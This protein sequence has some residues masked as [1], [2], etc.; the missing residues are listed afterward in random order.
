VRRLRR[1]AH[2]GLEHPALSTPAVAFVVVAFVLPMAVMVLYSFW[3]TRG[4]D[5]VRDFTLDNYRRLFDEPLYVRTLLR[6]F[7]VVGLSSL[8]TVAV[9]FPFAYFVAVKVRPR[10]RLAWILL[11]VLPFFTSYLIRVF[12]W[13]NIFGT[14]GAA[15]EAIRALGLSD[16]PVGF[17]QQGTSAIV[18]TFVYLLFPLAFLTSY[19]TLERMDPGLREAA[20]DLGAKPWQVLAKVTI[21][22]AGSGL[23][24]GFAF[25]FIAMAGDYVT[26]RLIGGTKGSLFSNLIVNQ[27]GLSVQWGYGA[28]LALVLLVSVLIFLILLRV[29][30]GTRAAGDF[31]RRYEYR[32]APVLAAYSSAFVMFLYLPIVLVVLFA[33]NTSSFVG[34]P[35]T[36]LTTSWFAEVLDDPDVIAAFWTSLEV[37]LWSVT[38]AILVGTPAAVQLA[39]TA[40]RRRD[41]R[42]TTLTLPLLVPPVVLGLGIII[43]LNALGVP[44]GFWLIVL[45]HVL[46]I[47]P[48]VVLV[49]LA[50]LEGMDRNQEL[51]AMDLG[52]PPWRAML[53]VTVP[54]S[55]P[56][57]LAAAMLGFAL[58]MDEFILTFLVTSTTTTLPLYVYSSLRF[59]IDPS[60][61]A[62]STLVLTASLAI[63][64]LAALAFAGTRTLRGRRRPVT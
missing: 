30:V 19:A 40:G 16:A 42:L 32:P 2:V 47:L 4:G 57:I 14:N 12:S 52:A 53:S 3:P 63:S 35:V 59:E 33:F 64:L 11:A 56:A 28:T 46:L 36:G 51:A 38:L 1:L 27:F 48:V 17:F 26:P 60:L 22:L 58:S 61:N 49:V 37:A 8:L 43:G 45:G 21:P 55:L 10:R 13:L 44:R 15:N 9:T 20:A 24:A 18:V 23:L 62:I 7:W 25:S 41:L 5:V 50:R 54:Q 31:T 34:F 39:R 29:V 6:T